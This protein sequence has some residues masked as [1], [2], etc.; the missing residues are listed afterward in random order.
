MDSLVTNKGYG[1][2]VLP[3]TM[4]ICPAERSRADVSQSEIS[5]DLPEIEKL[6][7]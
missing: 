1:A 2:F 7:L 5:V 6:H 3:K 4:C